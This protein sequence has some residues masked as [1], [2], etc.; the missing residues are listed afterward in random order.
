MNY[1]VLVKKVESKGCRLLW[2][3]EEFDQNKV[4]L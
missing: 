3:K 4:N 1:E 2:S